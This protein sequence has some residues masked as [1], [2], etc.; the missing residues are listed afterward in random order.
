[1]I[2]ATPNISLGCEFYQARWYL[3]EDVLC[4]PFPSD[5]EPAAAAVE[6]VVVAPSVAGRVV[7]DSAATL[8]E[9]LVHE[10][11]DV[12]RVSDWTGVDQL[13]SVKLD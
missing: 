4:E 13:A 10:T 5:G 7:L 12:E 1:M 2:A 6:R 9:R 3:E 11:R 8:I